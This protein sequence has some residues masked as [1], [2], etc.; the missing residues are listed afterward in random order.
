MLELGELC[1]P[2]FLRALNFYN[3]VEPTSV[4]CIGGRFLIRKIIINAHILRDPSHIGI[5]LTRVNCGTQV[6]SI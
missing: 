6:V 3:S 4:S 5:Q 2:C 1:V